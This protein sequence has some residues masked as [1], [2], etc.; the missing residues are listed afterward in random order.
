MKKSGFT[1]LEVVIVMALTCVIL[2]ILYSIFQAG[3]KV[4]SDADVRATLQM[5]ARNVQEELTN[6]GIQAADVTG[7][8]IG[9]S[10]SDSDNKAYVE[11]KYSGLSSRN[12]NEI[13]IL[14][15]GKDS[16]Y[17]IDHDSGEYKISNPLTYDI[18]FENGT[19]YMITETEAGTRSEKVIAKHIISFNVEPEDT[20][21][22]F[23]D[24]SSIKFNIV[25]RSQ[26]AFS[27]VPDY[28][29]DVKVTFRNKSK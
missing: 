26:K 16:E 18:K 11:Q 13:K 3:N 10:Y 2:G 29:I 1:L 9:S 25:L 28:P 6:L 19:L 12:I 5:E 22:S 23:A 14:G 17:A 21:D 15:Y 4:F 7:V 27:K 8:K 20:N 24:A